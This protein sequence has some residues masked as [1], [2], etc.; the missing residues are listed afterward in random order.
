MT[1]EEREILV[2]AKREEIMK[3]MTPELA[4]EL[5]E[6]DNRIAERMK[7]RPCPIGLRDYSYLEDQT[8]AT[9]STSEN[10]NN[11]DK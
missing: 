7:M 3:N 10:T 1:D 9:S 8:N 2:K 11:D 6:M 4:R 5:D